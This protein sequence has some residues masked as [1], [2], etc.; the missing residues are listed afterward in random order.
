M[1]PTKT[2]DDLQLDAVAQ[3][4]SY[5]YTHFAVVQGPKRAFYEVVN[6]VIDWDGE[7]LAAKTDPEDTDEAFADEQRERGVYCVFGFSVVEDKDHPLEEHPRLLKEQW[8]KFLDEVLRQIGG[9]SRAVVLR[10]G[11]EYKVDGWDI[12]D[13][14]KPAYSK[15]AFGDMRH[16][17]SDAWGGI[18]AGLGDAFLQAQADAIDGYEYDHEVNLWRKRTGKK[19]ISRLTLRCHFR[20]IEKQERLYGRYRD[21]EGPVVINVAAPMDLLQAVHTEAPPMPIGQGP[22]HGKEVSR[23]EEQCGTLIISDERRMGMPPVTQNELDALLNELPTA[24]DLRGIEVTEIYQKPE[25]KPA[26]VHPHPG[27]GKPLNKD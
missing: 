12:W 26:P 13:D 27:Q 4:H 11:L 18:R 19:F 22:C 20:G 3:V 25:P 5:L 21:G 10:R 24:Q 14:S 2:L 1:T 17:S 16:A 8:I 6:G 9:Q 7:N 15:A 23:F